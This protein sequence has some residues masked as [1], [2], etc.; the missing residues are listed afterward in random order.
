MGHLEFQ[1]WFLFV[2]SYA[3]RLSTIVELFFHILFQFSNFVFV[4]FNHL[5]FKFIQ[6]RHFYQLLLTFF[7][8]KNL[9]N[10]F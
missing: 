6:L 4:H 2:I 9:E 5:N 1:K 8:K 7:E 10:I 3:K